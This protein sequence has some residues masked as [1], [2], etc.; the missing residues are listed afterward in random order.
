LVV[1]PAFILAIGGSATL[2]RL[3]RTAMLDVM[4]QDYLRTARS[5]GLTETSVVF[6]HALRNALPPILTYMGL[7]IGFLLSGSII[8]EQ[9]LGLPGLGTWNLLAI[10][11][12]DYPIVMIFSLFAAA[13]LM[14]VNLLMDL[15]YAY[16]D[17][18]IRYS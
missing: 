11:A 10:T 18:R 2:M 15:L 3:T 6:R 13:I 12:K 4:R 17:P 16:L 8:L 14:T 5:K 7:Q 1:P 9:I